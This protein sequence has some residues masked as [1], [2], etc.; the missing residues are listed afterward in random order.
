MSPQPTSPN[1]HWYLL[2]R[3]QQDVPKTRRRVRQRKE[4]RHVSCLTEDSSPL[5]LTQSSTYF[6][7]FELAWSDLVEDVLST[8][9]DPLVG[10]VCDCGTGALRVYRCMDSGCLG[11]PARCQVCFLQ[12]HKTA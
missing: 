7:Q 12:A 10:Q 5:I 8:E 9:F 4:H 3:C 1:H 11:M 6:R 2:T